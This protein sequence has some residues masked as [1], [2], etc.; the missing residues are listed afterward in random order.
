MRVYLHHGEVIHL[1][2]AMAQHNETQVVFFKKKQQIFLLY[3]FSGAT[4]HIMSEHTWKNVRNDMY[5]CYEWR[6]EW[7]S[8]HRTDGPARI[9][10]DGLEEYYF[11]GVKTTKESLK[12]KVAWHRE[13]Y[14]W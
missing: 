12:E 3:Q 11:H 7:G 9:F 10:D 5:K 1:C 4:K 14:G 6:D 13:V 2:R 8:F